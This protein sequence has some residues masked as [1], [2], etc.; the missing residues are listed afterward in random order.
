MKDCGRL[1]RWQDTRSDSDSEKCSADNLGKMMK[2]IGSGLTV[3][4]WRKASEML[5]ALC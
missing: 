1:E 3:G 2:E 4:H 5:L